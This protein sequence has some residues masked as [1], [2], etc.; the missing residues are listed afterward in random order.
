L[1]LLNWNCC[2]GCDVGGMMKD[3]LI[4]QMGNTPMPNTDEIRWTNKRFHTNNTYFIKNLASCTWD[5]NEIPITAL[6]NEKIIVFL[7]KDVRNQNGKFFCE[8]YDDVFL[9]YRAGG[10]WLKEG[11]HLHNQLSQSLKNA[12]L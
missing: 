8:I 12:L 3:W 10:N 9:H 1:E 7:Q 11:I 6:H 4:K 5:T 2:E